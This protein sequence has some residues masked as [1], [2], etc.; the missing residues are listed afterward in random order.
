MEQLLLAL[1]ALGDGE[2]AGHLTTRHAWRMW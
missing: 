1:L 2:H